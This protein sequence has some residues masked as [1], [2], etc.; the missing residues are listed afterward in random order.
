MQKFVKL[1]VALGVIA[2]QLLQPAATVQAQ[3]DLVSP[4]LAPALTWND[5][6]QGERAIAVNGDTFAMQGTVYRAGEQF[7][8]E[9]AEDV[10]A[11]YSSTSLA[12]LG[13]QKVETF[14]YPNGVSTLY[15]H[16]AGVYV[17]V[18]FIGCKEDPALA[19]VTVW[20]S[21]PTDVVPSRQTDAAPQALGTLG[22]TSP[23]NGAVNV[24]TSVT[25]DWSG[26]TGTD[27][28]HYRFCYD[29]T[30]NA[31]C[32][33]A[34]AWTSVWDETFVDVSSL[35]SGSTYYWQV[36]A[37]LDD[38][39]KVD[40]NGGNWW[41][42]T[43][44]SNLPPG[45]FSKSFPVNGATGQ[46]STPTLVWQASTNATAYAYCIDTTNNNLCDNNWIS[47]GTNRHVTLLSGIGANIKYYW[48][49]RATNSA[50]LVFGNSNAWYSF[51]TAAGP[52]NDTIDSASTLAIPQEFKIS[53]TSATVDTDTTNACSANLGYASVWYKYTP[54]ANR[55]LYI[56][57][58]GSS[59]DTYISVWTRN[60][61]GTLNSVTCNDNDAGLAQ[62]NMNLPVT[63][64]ITYYIQVAQK[65][66]GSTP[67]A[68]AGGS[69][70]FH[71]RNFADVTGNSVYWKYIEGIYARGISGGCATSPDVLYCPLSN[72]TR[73][74]MAIFLLRAIH[75]SAYTP[76]AVGASTGF[77]DVP[78]NY[79][80]A[81]WIKQLAAEGVTSGCQVGL[82]CPES[83]V[84]RAQMAI[85]LLRAKHGSAYTPPAVGASTGFAD[86]PVS[87]WAAAWIKQLAA[88]GVTSGCGGG[89]YC[90]ENNVTR[91]QMAVFLSKTFAIPLLP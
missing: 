33:I 69:L 23:E 70:A 6:G 43:T 4:P 40:A 88:E 18:E 66:P 30:D 63:S 82:Y 53:T 38:N 83:P 59:Y 45:A 56:D 15:F 37:V 61:N 84:T 79:W 8:L 31:T 3:G 50:G 26:Y 77:A 58:F 76:P 52:V 29:K 39:T 36:Q 73:A 5:L 9:A 72:V 91:E 80:A 16:E 42:F 19:C 34:G 51:T 48:Q 62:S 10:S 35:D 11:Y 47:T 67:T 17:L 2:M 55:K 54:S 57:T 71:V 86:V 74:E 12:G 60:V 68:A 28:N 49:V 89:L 22:K 46:S 25:L 32:D 7:N 27:L 24:N 87:Y 65:N 90:P 41:S 14:H 13:W 64:G 44:I 21:V 78:V 85:F 1:L 20:Q 81:A 75:G